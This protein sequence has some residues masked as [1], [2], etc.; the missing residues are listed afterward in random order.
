MRWTTILGLIA[1]F[2]IAL[3]L[4]TGVADAPLQDEDRTGP[5]PQDNGTAT[6]DDSPRPPGPDEQEPGNDSDGTG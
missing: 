1:G 3:V 4:F 2:L 6:G 5:P